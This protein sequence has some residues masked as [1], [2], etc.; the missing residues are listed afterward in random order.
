SLYEQLEDALAACQGGQLVELTIQ[1]KSWYQDVILRPP[2]LVAACAF[3]VRL[4]L[5]GLRELLPKEPTIGRPPVIVLTAGAG[6]LPGL[7]G[8]L[9]EQAGDPGFV[10]V[11]SPD[12][13]ANAVHQFATSFHDGSLPPGHIDTTIPVPSRPRKVETRKP[14]H[15][16][17]PP[18]DLRLTSS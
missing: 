5:D 7:V 16:E 17:L 6:R 1:A 2:Q 18:R 12:A 9:Q 10:H 4:A 13:L 3:L 8:A 14:N 11:L 15:T